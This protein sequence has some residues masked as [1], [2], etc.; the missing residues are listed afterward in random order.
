M[1]AIENA[2]KEFRKIGFTDEK[3]IEKQL[4]IM[5]QNVGR[6]DDTN[7]LVNLFNGT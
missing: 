7:I 4:L 1:K 3:E 5:V 2:K 6:K